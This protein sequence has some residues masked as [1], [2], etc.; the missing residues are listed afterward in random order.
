MFFDT[1]TCQAPIGSDAW[2]YVFLSS[3]FLGA[4][5]LVKRK[6]VYSTDTRVNGS[7]LEPALRCL[8]ERVTS[9]WWK[10]RRGK[11]VRGA[12]APRGAPPQPHPSSRRLRRRTSRKSCAF[13]T[14]MCRSADRARARSPRRRLR[15]SRASAQATTSSR[16]PSRLQAR[17]FARRARPCWPGARARTRSHRSACAV[18]NTKPSPRRARETRPSVSVIDVIYSHAGTPMKERQKR[19]SRR[20][21][22]PLSRRERK[23]ASRMTKRTRARACQAR[24]CRCMGGCRG[25]S[26][27]GHGLDRRCV[28]ASSR[29]FAA[30]RARGSFANAPTS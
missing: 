19:F 12:K 23:L 26:G 14:I 9:R 30:T 1:S 11:S 2:L 16:A 10:A 5:L 15:R 8:R 21:R 20:R 29:R 3:A 13:D 18:S 6:K 22:R 4:T 7:S 24:T 27:A 28:W 25:V 17:E